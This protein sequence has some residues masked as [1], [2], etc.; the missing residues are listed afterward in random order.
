MEQLKQEL[1]N[2]LSAKPIE[3]EKDAKDHFLT[4]DFMVYIFRLLYT[5]QTIGKEV[6]KEQ[7]L[8]R[9]IQC[10]KEKDMA[11]YQAAL[12]ARTKDFQSVQMDMKDIV[13]D[14]FNIITKEYEIA[15]EKWKSDA[16]YA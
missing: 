7:H 12:E 13:F 4:R 8:E 9:R 3:P 2:E 11:G 6:V 5:Y 16:D 15:Y 1:L 10:L 14:Y